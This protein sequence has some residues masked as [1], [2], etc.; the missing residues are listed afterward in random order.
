MD[1]GQDGM[2]LTSGAVMRAKR[3]AFCVASR[4]NPRQLFESLK[5]TLHSCALPATKA[6]VGLDADDP[7]LAEAEA[8]LGALG[9]GRIVV[10]TAPREDSIGAVYNRCAAAVD[11]DIYLNAADDFMILTPGWDALVAKEASVF[12]D[13]IGMIGVGPLP[14]PNSVLP[15][16]EATTRGLID[17]M[18]Y[19]IQPHTPYW[20]MDNWLYEIAAMIG[21]T[22]YMPMDVEFVGPMRTRGLR[23]IVYWANF[24]SKMR[25]HRCAIAKSIL[26]SPDLLMSAERRQELFDGMDDMCAMFE[27]SLAFLIE[28]ASVEGAEAVGFDAPDD[29]RY[30]RIKARSMRVLEELEQSGARIAS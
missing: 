14:F 2:A 26:S 3:I 30:R 15:A 22:H 10:S 12:P 28:R 27:R 8:L 17:K 16:V 13:G 23:E 11:A 18:G 1:A 24:F 19:F 25:A 6:I 7:T 5:R 21:R 9:G 4:G 29:E 20:W